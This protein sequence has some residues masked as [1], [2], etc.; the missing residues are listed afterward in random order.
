M[1]TC[2]DTI[3]TL[4]EHLSSCRALSEQRRKKIEQLEK[5]IQR[6]LGRKS[7]I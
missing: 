5:E 7:K 1:V 6:L 2:V 4:K 3:A